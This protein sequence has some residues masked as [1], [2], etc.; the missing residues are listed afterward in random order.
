MINWL[1]KAV[2]FG[3]KGVNPRNLGEFFISRR[4]KFEPSNALERMYVA[5]P[6]YFMLIL[7]I[8]I[9][10][11]D[12]SS[13]FNTLLKSLSTISMLILGQLFGSMSAKLPKKSNVPV[14][15]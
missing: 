3:S 4:F 9:F 10:P 5:G 13:K 12:A 2:E 15:K 8:F 6:E 14:G 7:S 11:I 1:T